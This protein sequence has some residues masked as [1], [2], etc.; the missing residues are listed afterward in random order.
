VNTGAAAEPIDRATLERTSNYSPV[1][2][3][4]TTDFQSAVTFSLVNEEERGGAD[5]TISLVPTSKISGIV[6]MADGS[7]PAPVTLTLAS[8]ADSAAVLANAPFMRAV[9]ARTDPEG[10]FVFEDVPSGRFKVMAKLESRP[11]A[12]ARPPSGAPSMVPG[13]NPFLWASAVVDMQGTPVSVQLDLQPSQTI[14]GRLVFDGVSPP[15]QDVTGLSIRLIPPGT[16]SVITGPSGNVNSDRTFTLNGVTPDS[17]RMLELRRGPWSGA[18]QLKSAVAGGRDAFDAP[19]VVAAGDNLELV[20]TYTDRPSEIIGMFQDASGRPAPDYFIVI[21]PADRKFW[22]ST[23]RL[24]STRP[25]SDG[26]YSI[27]GLPTGEYLIAALTDF[28]SEDTYAPSFLSEL[29][30]MAAKVAITEGQVTR[31]DLKIG[32]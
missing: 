15:P 5:I 23:R 14:T 19:L 31:Q 4:A 16:G 12:A 28:R 3:P 9:N 18:W 17:Y 13:S 11:A 10:R 21:F 22:A 25:A 29:S 24:L 26:H 20:L 27:K 30:T 32:K 1:F 2:H 6:R 8:A 7:A